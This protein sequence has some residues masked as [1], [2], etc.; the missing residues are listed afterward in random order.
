[1]GSRSA[2]QLKHLPSWRVWVEG[3][4][5]NKGYQGQKAT[6]AQNSAMDMQNKQ[7]RQPGSQAEP[8]RS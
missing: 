8:L 2:P 6:A 4:L 1:M 7:I 3:V 5:V